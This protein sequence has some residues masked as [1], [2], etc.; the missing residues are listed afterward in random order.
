MS[1]KEE[2]LTKC[3]W[4]RNMDKSQME[5]IQYKGGKVVIDVAQREIG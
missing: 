4:Q 1:R 5:H 2:L 3:P